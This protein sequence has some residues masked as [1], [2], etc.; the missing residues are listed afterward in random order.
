MSKKRRFKILDGQQQRQQR[1]RNEWLIGGAE[2]VLV[3]EIADGEAKGRSPHFRLVHFTVPPNAA[4]A[5]GARVEVK[6]TAAFPNSLRGE[7]E[8]PAH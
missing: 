1:E 8:T 5:P 6:I 3:D 4:I 7:L 2:E